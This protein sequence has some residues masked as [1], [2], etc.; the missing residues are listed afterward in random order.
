MKKDIPDIIMVIG[1]VIYHVVLVCGVVFLIY[2]FKNFWAI[3]LLVLGSFNLKY[4]SPTENGEDN[5]N[6]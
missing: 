2:T 1:W 6:D 3:T 5:G 4:K